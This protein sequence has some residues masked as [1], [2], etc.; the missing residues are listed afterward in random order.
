VSLQVFILASGSKANA[1][2]LCEGSTRVLIDA[3]LGI[4]SLTAAL[5]EAGLRP[6]QISAVLLTHEHTDHVRGLDSLLSRTHAPLYATAGTLRVV[7]FMVPARVKVTVMDH[8]TCEIGPF[9]VRAV[10]VPHDAAEPC[11]YCIETDGHRLTFATDLGEVP[12]ELAHALAH[13][14]FAMLESNHDVRMLRYGSYPEFLKERI[15]SPVG[16]LSNAQAARAL[17]AAAGNGLQT[18]VLAHLSD[19]NNDPSLAHR[20]AA[21]ALTGSGIALHV[22]TRSTMGPF[23]NLL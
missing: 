18:V 4:R 7:D 9:M 16:H 14:T 1:V 22:T 12:E 8:G 20:V 3:G 17:K 19:E 6:D 15:L 23:L 10:P 2:L 21:K 11:G 5:G 13:S